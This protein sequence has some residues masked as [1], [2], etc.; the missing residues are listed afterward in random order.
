MK[1]KWKLLAFL[2][3]IFA[4]YTVDRAM[5]GPLALSVQK[6]VGID[7]IQFGVLNA[8]VFWAYAAFVPVAGFL[9]DRYDRSLLIGG[10]T[11]LWSAMM[12]FA[13][14]AGGFWSLLLLVSVAV[15]VP[16]TVYSPA[17]AALISDMHKDTRGTAMAVHQGAFYSGYLVSGAVA[18]AFLMAFGSWRTAYWTMGAVGLL[19]GVAFLRFRKGLPSVRET[20]SP[21]S[22]PSFF[23]A[24]KAF[25]GCPTAVLGALGH[26]AFTFV[27]F[28]Y[29]SWGP[30]FVALKCGVAPEAAGTGVMLF[31]FAPALAAVLAA[32]AAA[33]AL[34]GRF[35]R[36]RL[37]VQSVSLIAAAPVL[38]WFGYSGSV[39]SAWASAAIFGVLKGAFEANSVNSI[40]DVVAPRYRAS[41]MGY[42]NV[43]SGVLGSTAPLVL[44]W[45]SQT[46][47]VSGLSFGFGAFGAVLAVAAALGAIA[48]FFTFNADRRRV[49]K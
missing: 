8:A 26:V 6:D 39:G 10:A 48:L 27:A 13:G 3:A 47:G 7:D 32:G 35:P 37:A 22:A 18:A 25:F 38:L 31:H 49:L 12:V 45:L 17:A 9:G 1:A 29:C 23:E 34:T 14:F 41:A 24:A 15:T 33:N 46:R 11:V 20:E 16:Q 21:R 44:G 4:V 2:C 30:K 40:F 28:G 19:L 5:L 43:L 36:F 42:L